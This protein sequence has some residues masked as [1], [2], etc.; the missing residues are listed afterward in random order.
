MKRRMS[1]KLSD[2]KSSHNGGS[3]EIKSINNFQQHTKKGEQLR[4]KNY[5]QSRSA[6]GVK[7]KE[8]FFCTIEYY[9]FF[10][11]SIF[12]LKEN[13]FLFMIP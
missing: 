1:K 12:R 6:L 10:A 4:K 11:A 3:K 9:S 8:I 2:I 7:R 13:G 5:L